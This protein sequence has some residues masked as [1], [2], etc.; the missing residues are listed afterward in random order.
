MA[1]RIRLQRHGKKGKAVFHLVVADSRAKRDGKF[2]E[3]LGVYN[4]NTNP[5]TIDINFES[6]LKWVG[7]GA[8]MSDTARAILSYKGVLYKNHLLKGVTKGALTAEQVETKFS[9]WEADKASKIQGK[10]EGLGKDA[11][12]DKAARLKAEA[13][14]NEAKAKAIEAKNTPA[15]EEAPVV[16]EAATEETAPEAVTE[17]ATE[18]PAE[19]TAPEAAAEETTEAPAEDAPAAEEEGEAKA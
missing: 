11:V 17:E 13:E 8:E 6:T 15:A 10:I 3:K 9:A 5:A 2:I 19:E 7:T 18:A 12:A 16:E 14:S 1:T 4:P